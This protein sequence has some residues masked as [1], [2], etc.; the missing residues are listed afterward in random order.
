VHV[1]EYYEYGINYLTITNGVEKY[2]HNYDE[3]K[4]FKDSATDTDIILNIHNKNKLIE[5][6]CK[7]KLKKD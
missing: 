5:R 6:F 4:E 3:Y 2:E 7:H 1:E